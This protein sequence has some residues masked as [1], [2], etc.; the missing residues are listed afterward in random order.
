MGILFGPPESPDS[1]SSVQKRMLNS[2]P[3]TSILLLSY[4]SMVEKVR[5]CR[6]NSAIV[7]FQGLLLKLTSFTTGRQSKT[8][9][10]LPLLT[11]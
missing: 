4:R 5:V 11:M 8:K 1:P 10:E 2:E 3:H 7:F 9:A 6:S